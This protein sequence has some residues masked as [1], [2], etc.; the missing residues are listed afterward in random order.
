MSHR[1]HQFNLSTRPSPRY[2]APWAVPALVFACQ[3]RVEVGHSRDPVICVDC[4]EESAGTTSEPSPTPTA[5]AP[6]SSAEPCV[7]DRSTRETYETWQAA[8]NDFGALAGTTFSGYIENG[9]DITL[10]LGSDQSARLLVG[11]SVPLPMAESGYL[12][13]QN[14]A[15]TLDCDLTQLIEGGTYPLHGTTLT[16]SRFKAP[17]PLTA[18]FDEWCALQTPVP[19]GDTCTYAVDSPSEFSLSQDNCRQGGA[20]VDCSWLLLA[21]A[22]VCACTETECFAWAS[23]DGAGLDLRLSDDGT[24]LSGSLLSGTVHLTRK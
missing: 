21:Q 19:Q 24:E 20:P 11:E 1:H 15:L 16:G 3:P 5:L 9:P 17:V 18:A 14:T 22:F 23:T 13:H 7:P 10:T 6:I 2:L 8:P 4:N 12:C